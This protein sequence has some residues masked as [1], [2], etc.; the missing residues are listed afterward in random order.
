MILPLFF[1]RFNLRKLLPWLL[2]FLLAG[3]AVVWAYTPGPLAS[4]RFVRGEMPEL[5]TVLGF[6]GDSTLPTFVLSIL[7]SLLM[8]LAFTLYGIYAARSLITKP[9]EDG[10]MAMLFAAR[11]RRGAILLTLCLVI[12]SGS[13]L[14]V[15]FVL[16]GQLAAV[17]VFFPK[18]DLSALFRVNFGFLA[19]A[20]ICPAFSV[21]M[22]VV[23]YDETRMKR[24]SAVVLLLMLVFFMASRLPGWTSSL[25]WFTFWT[26]F[27]GAGLAFGSAD[28]QRTLAAAMISVFLTGLS[29]WVFRSRE[30]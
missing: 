10:R 8:P 29:L 16:L 19:A 21:L 20:L 28:W 15:L 3:A 24:R 17:L 4:L 2:V 13:V 30:L 5:F 1:A 9:L 11:Y 18:A 7:F 14:L 12:F 22:S 27:D 23:S 26:L 25:R 6:V